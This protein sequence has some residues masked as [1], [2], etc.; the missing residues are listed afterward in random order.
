MGARTKLNG[1]HILGAGLIGGLFGTLCQ[2]WIVFLIVLVIVAA[3]A[4]YDGSIRLKS[5]V[6]K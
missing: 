4:V 3:V 5:S 6:P 2:S 1:A